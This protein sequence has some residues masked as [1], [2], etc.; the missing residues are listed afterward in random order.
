MVF[1]CIGAIHWVTI[2]VTSC[3]CIVTPLRQKKIT[4]NRSSKQSEQFYYR[5]LLLVVYDIKTI[6]NMR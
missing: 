1:N 2:R 6:K 3:L 4:S 5:L